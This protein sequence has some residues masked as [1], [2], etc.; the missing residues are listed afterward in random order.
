[1]TNEGSTRMTP[2]MYERVGHAGRKPS[3]FSWRIR[4]A[5]AHKGV[6]VEFRPTRFADVETIRRLSGQH[7]VPVVVD[8]DRVV[9]DSWSIALWLEERYPDHPSLFGGTEGRGVTR[10]VNHW[11]D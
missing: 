8:G 3:P 9:H 1:M 7:R 6:E 4:Y 5:I 10:V 2:I 11:S